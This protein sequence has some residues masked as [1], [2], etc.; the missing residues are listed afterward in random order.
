MPGPGN[1]GER[2]RNLRLT[3]RLSQA[4]LAGHDLSDSYISLIESGKRTPTPTVL[5][6]LAERLGCTPEY[7]AEG[8]E[9]EQRAHLEVRE[10]HAHLALLGGDPA[11]AEAG[12][13]EVIARS[14]D[15]DLTARARWG[16]ARALEE[17]GRTDHAIALFEELREQAE[18]DP[19]RA[20]WLPPVIALARCYHS[21]GDLGQAI[22]LGERA[23]ERLRRLGLGVGQEHTEVGRVLLLAYVDRS[24]PVRAHEIGRRLLFPDESGEAESTSIA[25]QR[26]S[27]RA[28][29]EGTIGDSLY[30][31]DQALAARTDTTPVQGRARLHL[32]AA[33][34]LLRGVMPFSEATP[35]PLPGG[36]VGA[37]PASGEFTATG[38]PGAERPRVEG[39]H[40]AAQEALELLKETSVL[41][42]AEATESTIARARALVLT[43]ELEEAI[44]ELE[45]FLDTGMALADP[46][47]THP[48]TPHP[49]NDL[50]ARTQKSVLARLVLARARVAQGDLAA[51]QVVLRAASEQLCTLPA[52]RPAAHLYRELGE[53]FELVQ[54][55]DS[56]ATAYRQALE[57]AGLRA[58][59]AQEANCDLGRV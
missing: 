29:D 33:K 39:S 12:F 37:V 16:R 46:T 45:Q 34:A 35:S 27:M 6:M 47:G 41:V 8:V 20:S 52:G 40:Q 42:G 13:D 1:V 44:G 53:L 32:A 30:F 7:L 24:D 56:A 48:V 26:A 21:V 49:G 9:P 25:Y 19:G 28:L 23:L 15:P 22:A 11:T 43:S 17:L 38:A 54:D 18:R 14:D 55:S 58:A 5:R 51:A 57:A 59:R 50:A 31:A 10:R 3:R 4:Q 2:V 36:T